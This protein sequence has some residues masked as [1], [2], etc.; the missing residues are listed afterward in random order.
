MRRLRCGTTPARRGVL[1]AVLGPLGLA[2]AMSG[3]A[4]SSAEP[5]LAGIRQLLDEWHPGSPT[6]MSEAEADM[7]IARAITAH[8]MRRP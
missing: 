7:V 6:R 8:E 2:I 5:T 3:C 1:L 4:A